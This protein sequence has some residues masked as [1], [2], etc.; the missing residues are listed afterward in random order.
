MTSQIHSHPVAAVF[1]SAALPLKLPVKFKSI[2]ERQVWFFFIFL[3]F[4]TVFVPVVKGTPREG[5]DREWE[6]VR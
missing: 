2:T 6:R 3:L 5:G 4:T 1:W